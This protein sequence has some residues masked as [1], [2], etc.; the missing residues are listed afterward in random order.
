MAVCVAMIKGLQCVGLFPSC[1]KVPC[2]SA[3]GTACSVRQRVAAC[4]V[5][6][7]PGPRVYMTRS[8]VTRSHVAVCVELCY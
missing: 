7:D 2:C 8:V 4:V 3:C 5:A 1:H 6:V